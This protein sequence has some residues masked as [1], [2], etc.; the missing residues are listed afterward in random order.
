[1]HLIDFVAYADEVFCVFGHIVCLLP[2]PCS[3]RGGMADD[4]CREGSFFA[5]VRE[6]SVCPFGFN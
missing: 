5:R 1:M 4:H 3:G 6:G 2:P